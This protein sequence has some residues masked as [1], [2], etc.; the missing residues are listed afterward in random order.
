[1][2]F[3]YALTLSLSLFMRRI[4]LKPVELAITTLFLLSVGGSRQKPLR[5]DGLITGCRSNGTPLKDRVI[6]GKIKEGGWGIV[7]E[8]SFILDCGKM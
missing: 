6:S 1:M 2:N 3:A 8:M 7:V 4:H 5:E